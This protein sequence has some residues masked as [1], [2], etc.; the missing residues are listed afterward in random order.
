M[1]TSNGPWIAEVPWAEAT[2]VLKEAYDWQAERLGEPTEFTVLGSLY[3]E[4][5][6]ERLRLYKVVESCPSGL[7]PVERLLAALIASSLNDTPHC[8]SGLRER[9]A[10]E[11][12]D[13]ELVETVLADPSNRPTGDGR[14]DAAAAYAAKLT[15]APGSIVAS[16]IDALRAAGFDDLEILDLNNMVAYFNYVNR[17]AN[18]LGLRSE[19]PT[20]H[21]LRAAPH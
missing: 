15:T 5:V 21:A 14:I 11:G 18:G 3:P 9:L 4:L 8:L 12:V 2:G 13:A 17:V 7:G 6:L 10:S 19:I 1:T 16:D 20:D